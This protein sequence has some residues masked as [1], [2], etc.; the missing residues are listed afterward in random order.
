MYTIKEAH[1]KLNCNRQTVNNWIKRLDIE[2]ATIDGMYRLTEEQYNMIADKVNANRTN[3]YTNE[4][5]NRAN[6]DNDGANNTN[7]DTNN[8]TESNNVVEI[9]QSHIEEQRNTIRDLSRMLDQQ[10]QLTQSSNKKVSKLENKLE[11]YKYKLEN[12]NSVAVSTDTK[13]VLKV[14]N[15]KKVNSNNVDDTYTYEDAHTR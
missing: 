14:K 12:S 6:V 4:H 1:E 15:R 8:N 13:R 2:V 5:T 11:E 7:Q 3:Q 9:L 10:Q